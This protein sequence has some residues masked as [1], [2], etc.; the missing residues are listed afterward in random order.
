V[1]ISTQ[2]ALLLNEFVPEDV[3]IV[4]RNEGQSSF[5][6][7]DSAQLSEWL[8]DYTLGELWQKN[9]LGGRPHVESAGAHA[10]NEE[11]HS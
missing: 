4:E 7:L 10:A 6:R 5:R 8:A 2:S 3:I 1:I 9:L 11:L